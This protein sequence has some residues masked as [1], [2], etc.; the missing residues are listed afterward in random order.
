MTLASRVNAE[1]RPNDSARNSNGEIGK[2]YMLTVWT[3]TARDAT[4][5]NNDPGTPSRDYD[6][7]LMVE[8]SREFF[9][10][11]LGAIGLDASGGDKD[12]FG[13]YVVLS[14]ADTTPQKIVDVISDLASKAG[15]NDAL[16]VYIL[17]LYGGT[18][19][20]ETRYNEA[21]SNAADLEDERDHFIMPLIDSATINAQDSILRSNLLY[22]MRSRKH[23][24]DVLITDSSSSSSPFV[25]PCE[26][27]ADVPLAYDASAN[28]ALLNSANKAFRYLLTHASGAYSWNSTNPKSF[29]R[30][31]NI[32][33]L[34]RT[35]PQ[36]SDLVEI[37]DSSSRD[38]E[39]SCGHI[40]SGSV[41]NRAFVCAASRPIVNPEKGYDFDDFFQD[42]GRDYDDLYAEYWKAVF[43][44]GYQ[45]SSSALRVL[46]QGKS[47]L[48]AFNAEDERT[49]DSMRNKEIMLK[50]NNRVKKAFVHRDHNEGSGKTGAPTVLSRINVD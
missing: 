35:S 7:K 50:T 10:S 39:A 32:D 36:M 18:A 12:V 48:T 2:I 46:P 21:L 31:R 22:W 4:K 23:R 5:E 30:V 41:F 47:T 19:V 44:D 9:E 40:R 6:F 14:G 3:G 24:L 8:S 16:F 20:Q 17:S 29:W 45:T 26:M 37:R 27:L 49:S 15:E 34:A 43:D 28:P 13:E 33:D 1:S 42:L 11:N 38:R 25:I